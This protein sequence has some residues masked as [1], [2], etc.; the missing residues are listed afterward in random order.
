M[1]RPHEW[2]A[3]NEGTEA[4]VKPVDLTSHGS[5]VRRSARRSRRAGVALSVLL[6]MAA[7]ACGDAEPAPLDTPGFRVVLGTGQQQFEPLDDD[8]PVPLIKG[9]QGGWHVWTSFLAYG[10]DTDVLR[11]DLTTRWEGVDESVLGGPGNVAVRPVRDASGAAALA[12]VGWPAV[13]FNPTCAHGHFLRVTLTVNDSEGRSARD[14]RRWIMEVP[15]ADRSS[16]CDG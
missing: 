3:S 5:N 8:V 14:T 16:D 4:E 2:P 15:E 6:V 10:F 12:S 1:R 11:M 9:I 7:S 13:V